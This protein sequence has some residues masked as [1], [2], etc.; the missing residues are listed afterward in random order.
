M[1]ALEDPA[2]LCWL[3]STRQITGVRTCARR[4][5]AVTG[6]HV[7]RQISAGVT[8]TCALTAE[9]KA[10]CW[11]GGYA[12]GDAGWLGNGKV[13][14]SSMPVPV[15]GDY[16]FAMLSV[17]SSSTCGLTTSGVAYCWGRNFNGEV[18]DG[19]TMSKDAPVPVS[20]QLRFTALSV[21]LSNACGITGSG[22]AYCWGSNRYGQLGIG[23]VAFNNIGARTETPARVASDLKFTR[24]A[25]GGDHT[26]A[27]TAS[28]AAYC[29]GRN[30]NASQLGDR[31]GVTHRGIPGPVAGNLTFATLD[32]D[33]TTTCASTESAE[34][35]CWGGGYFGALG[36]GTTTAGGRDHPSP[37]RGGAI[38]R[39]LRRREPCLRN[40]HGPKALL[41]GRPVLRPT[42]HR[43]KRQVL[44]SSLCM[45]PA[46]TRRLGSRLARLSLT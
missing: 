28:G 3:Y 13:Q 37:T 26:C 43:M 17:G 34:T 18:G 40:R 42:C 12:P 11:G 6:G 15:S 30:E 5:V 35:F 32:T 45:E 39:D 2:Q 31:S 36:D 22:E 1:R 21:G 38:H 29:W 23:N 33:I 44:A 16:A 27:L 24:I 46:S 14:R 41:L 9:G 8:H 20:G 10:Y 19:T 4:P 25:A 7:F